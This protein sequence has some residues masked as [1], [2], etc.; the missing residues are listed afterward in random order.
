MIV[1][2]ECINIIAGRVKAAIASRDKSIIQDLARRQAEK[3]ADF[4]EVNIGVSRKGG[5]DLM[6]WMVEAI[7]EVVD[8]PLSLDTTNAAAM[9]AGLKLAKRKAIV[10][11]T[12][13]TQER[14]GQMVPL[15]ARY[16]AGLIALTLD[17]AGLP[18][19]VD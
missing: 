11:S 17:E 8:I 1:I 12:D 5:E 3:G 13:A 9:E 2:G 4:L 16:G 15:A 18:S 14:L 19:T 10:N 7:Q 6:A